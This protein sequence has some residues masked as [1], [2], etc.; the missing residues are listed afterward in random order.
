MIFMNDFIFL[1]WARH[2]DTPFVF[3]Y[4]YNANILFNL[5]INKTNMTCNHLKCQDEIF[6]IKKSFNGVNLIA[7]PFFKL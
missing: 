7:F 3:T 6:A 2:P 5:S 4:A 1:E